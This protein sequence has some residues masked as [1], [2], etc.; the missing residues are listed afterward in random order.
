M[1]TGRITEIGAVVE[2]APADFLRPTGDRSL[3]PGAGLGHTVTGTS[4]KYEFVLLTQSFGQRPT[5]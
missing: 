1:V 4:L 5:T 2:A 3:L